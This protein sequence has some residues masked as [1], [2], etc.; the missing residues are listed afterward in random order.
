MAVA[1]A[2]IRDGLPLCEILEQAGISGEE[3][4][5]WVRAGAFPELAASLARGFAQADAPYVWSTLLREAKD[6][7][8]PAIRLYFDIWSKKMPASASREGGLRDSGVES[9]RSD[10]FGL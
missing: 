8:V 5:E 3:F 1:L 4:V 9:L 6:G 10:L 7:N 2:M